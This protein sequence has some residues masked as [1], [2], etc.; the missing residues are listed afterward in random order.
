MDSDNL[1]EAVGLVSAG[2]IAIALVVIAYLVAL[3]V[4]R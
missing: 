4:V 1:K 2:L 3:A